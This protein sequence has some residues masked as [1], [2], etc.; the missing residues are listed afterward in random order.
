MRKY[1]L[2]A[3]I[4]V[5]GWMGRRK[6]VFLGTM[7]FFCGMEI[8]GCV[9]STTGLRNVING[10]GRQE[11]ELFL[12]GLF[13]ICLGVVLWEIYAPLC[14]YLR[15]RTVADA[16]RD[17][18]SGL[19][20]HLLKL[21][22]AYHDNTAVGELL[23]TFTNDCASVERIYSND[24]YELI[25]YGADGLGGIMIM[26]VIDW[27]F[28]LVVFT[29]GCIS[30]LVAARFSTRL[31]K[32]GAEEQSRLARTSV[33][34]YELIEA[35]KTIRLFHLQEKKRMQMKDTTRTEAD[36]K[37]MAGRI[38]SEMKAV[39]LAINGGVYIAILLAGALFVR[40]GLSDWGTV[41]ALMSLKSVAD[42]LFVYC[43][44]FMA[45]M[46]KNL[47]GAKR[48]MKIMDKGQE[49]IPPC[50]EL[51]KQEELVVMSHV[52]FSYQKNKK[53]LDDFSMNLAQGKLT[54]L[55][56][57]SGSGKSTVMKILLAFYIPS[58]GKVAFRGTGPISLEMVRSMTAYVP[59]DAML[60]NGSIRANIMAGKEELTEEEVLKAAKEAGAHAFIQALPEGYDTMLTDN[61]SNLSG[62]QRQRIAI[63]R[64]LAKKAPVLL[65]DEV[66]S[67]L[68]AETAQRL[69][70]TIRDISRRKAV[71]WITH[72]EYVKR[73]ADHVYYVKNGV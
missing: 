49:D 62:G 25:R 72:D 22:M 46:Q 47:A 61:G 44:Q 73:L 55:A 4:R 5:I 58:A 35:A 15:D 19:C 33:N 70:E 2:S 28:A 27:R 48:L 23:S 21:P 34:A 37:R 30:V 9:L 65:L 16:M 40:F 66:T 51:R 32:A 10:A 52:S 18:K 56:G 53:V 1:N 60:E 12:S 64:A 50:F 57:E 6:Y 24:L 11:S 42:M 31:E 67:A 26:A 14:W 39:S 45:N 36:V 20:A 69:A 38:D 29:L 8:F 3:L 54:V 7:I 17:L 68:D 71:L 59:Q 43:V 41:I 13:R 63:A